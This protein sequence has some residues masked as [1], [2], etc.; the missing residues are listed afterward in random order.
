MFKI[1]ENN[2]ELILNEKIFG[3]RDSLNL[4]EML[5]GYTSATDYIPIMQEEIKFAIRK[6]KN[7]K[8]PGQDS[9]RN[10]NLKSLVD[11]MLPEVTEFLNLCVVQGKST[12]KAVR[13][14][15]NEIN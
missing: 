4:E 7:G 15:V 12:V 13:V 8:A 14:L 3:E 11:I 1:W 9:I 10:E 6:M 2:F 5:R